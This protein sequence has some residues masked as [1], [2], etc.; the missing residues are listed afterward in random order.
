MKINDLKKYDLFNKEEL[1]KL[2]KLKNQGLCNT[3]YKLTTNKKEYLIRVFNHTH[4]DE[5]SR[6]YEFSVQKKAYLKDIAAKP[7]LLDENNSLMICEF[8]KGKHKEKLNKKDLNNLVG[9]IKK[10]HTIKISK[11][12]YNLKKDFKYYKKILKDKKSQETVKNSLKELKKIQKYKFEAVTSHHD[13][14]VNNVLFH[15]NSLKLI[16]WEFACVN[17]RFFDLANICFEFKLNENQEKQVLKRYFKKIRK[18]DMKKLASYK[19]IYENLW[20]LWFKNL[21]KTAV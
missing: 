8:L 20:I 21:E 10:L 16:D 6:E 2:K 17:D 12:V 19:I 3:I 1:K 9:A 14:N 18:K 11:K 7:Y 5:N 15:K 4:L 13:I